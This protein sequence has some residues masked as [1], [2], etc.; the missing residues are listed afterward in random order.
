MGET[1]KYQIRRTKDFPKEDWDKIQAIIKDSGHEIEHSD[2]YYLLWE[3]WRGGGKT[4]EEILREIFSDYVGK[5]IEADVWFME[6][7]PDDTFYI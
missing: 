2:E 4:C 1:V 6:R 5:G 7:D 3:G